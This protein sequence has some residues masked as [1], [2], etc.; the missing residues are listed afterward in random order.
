MLF[1]AYAHYC[2]TRFRLYAG[3][4]ASLAEEWLLLLL[5]QLLLLPH[6][7]LQAL[8]VLRRGDDATASHLMI[9]C[10][11]SVRAAHA[12]A[13]STRLGQLEGSVDP[14]QHPSCDCLRNRPCG[15]VQSSFRSNHAEAVQL[16][17]RNCCHCCH[18][19]RQKI[20]Y[21]A[22][23]LVPCQLLYHRWQPQS[24]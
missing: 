14:T 19:C 16:R 3:A 4:R 9:R 1:R 17:R 20:S 13:P 12:H 10:E 2:N 5:L 23:D 15:V 21:G 7:P 6:L 11:S 22:T 24:H 18:C 8:P